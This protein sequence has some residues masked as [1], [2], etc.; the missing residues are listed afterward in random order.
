M[1]EVDCFTRGTQVAHALRYRFLCLLMT[2]AAL[3]GCVQTATRTHLAPR[4][5][6]GA[7]LLKISDNLPVYAP[8]GDSVVVR[9]VADA[10]DSDSTCYALHVG[11]KGQ[12]ASTLLAGSLPPGTYEFPSI[13]AQAQSDGPCNHR[14][15]LKLH[16]SNFGKFKV[17]AGRLTYLGVL[18]RTGGREV[19]ESYMIPMLAAAPENVD[20]ILHMVFPELQKL[21]T[22]NPQGWIAG[23]LPAARAQAN[24]Y[25]LLHAYGMFSPSQSADGT[26]IF[27]SRVGVVRSWHEGQAEPAEH[28]T[29]HRVALIT[30]AMLPDNSWLVAGDESTLLVS[31]DEGRSWR[32][33]R[34]DLPFGL[35]INVAPLANDLLLTL[36]DGRDVLVF[37]GDTHSMHWRKVAAY[38]TEFAFWTGSRGVMPE[39]WLVGDTYVTTL[40]SRHLGLYHA[41]TGISETRDM[42]GSIM[43]FAV[44]DDHVLRCDC[45]AVLAVNPYE[46]SDLGKTWKSSVFNRYAALPGMADSEHGV[47][48]Y[49]E[50]LFKAP[51]MA[52][53]DDGGKTWQKTSVT[54][55][56]NLR[57]F[58]YSRDRKTVYASNDADTL[59]ISNDGGRHWAS[60]I[61]IYLP[62]GDSIYP[63]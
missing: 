6:D 5:N 38:K 27:G 52:Y 57:H 4:D 35:I 41:D 43:R 47:D 61:H 12:S 20:E 2:A 29:G 58:F 55:P 23:S 17:S 14:D 15:L 7:V 30:T 8:W 11:L 60:A 25:A 16:G 53:T 9:R 31:A 32:S 45:T 63:Q 50:G 36:M 40:P 26:W 22:R 24:G 28:D 37:R 3:S 44:S 10:S 33:R 34:G 19:Q 62:P 18:E 51:T 21:D 48:W 59:W 1:L 56:L 13:G 46:S 39:S 54:P 49:K 42:P